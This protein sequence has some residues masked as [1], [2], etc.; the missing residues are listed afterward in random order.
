MFSPFHSFGQRRSHRSLSV[1]NQTVQTLV[2]PEKLAQL[3][4]FCRSCEQQHFV[5]LLVTHALF[6][7][8][9]RLIHQQCLSAE[10]I[11]RS[12]RA[13]NWFTLVVVESCVILV[14]HTRGH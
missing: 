1:W 9:V 5:H 14:K 10:R 11:P 3:R 4:G 2:S 8:S 7:K 6:I 13:Q 12:T